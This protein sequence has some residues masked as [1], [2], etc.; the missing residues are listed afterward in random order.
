MRKALIILSLIS[1]CFLSMQCSTEVGLFVPEKEV[2]LIYPS[3]NLLCIENEIDFIWE[4]SLIGINQYN[5]IVSKDRAL[6]DI[7]LNTTTALDELSLVLE[8]G[9][10]Y[11]W[12]V[13]ALDSNFNQTASSTISAF[14]TKGEAAINYVPFMAELQ[15][16]SNLSAISAGNLSLTWKGSDADI[17]DVLTYELFFGENTT[18]NLIDDSLSDE[19]YSVNVVSGKTYSWQVNV[20]DN[21]GAK[22]IGQ[23]WS[24]TV[25]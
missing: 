18:L 23:V 20:K 3:E 5:I 4:S 22:S 7:V 6:S 16:P 11:Y 13:K 10:A 25:D 14:Y 9:T 15:A 8:K 24:F 17:T 21:F 2:E 1:L 19:N 12:Q